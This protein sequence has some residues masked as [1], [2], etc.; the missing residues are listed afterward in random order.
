MLVTA[1]RIA[2][3]L[4]QHRRLFADDV[5]LL[6]GCGCLSA[7]AAIVYKL[8]PTIYIYE[9]WD[10]A[11]PVSAQ[12]GHEEFEHLFWFLKMFFTFDVLSWATIYAVKLSFL[13]FFRKLIR[14]LSGMITYWK[15]VLATTLTSGGFNICEVFITCPQPNSPLGT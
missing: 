5:P 7:A 9:D 3:R 11:A 4:H 2:I 12:L 15:I 6:F 13:L 10:G 1:T 14:R 8:L